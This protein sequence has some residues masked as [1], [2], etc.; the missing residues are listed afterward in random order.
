MGIPDKVSTKKGILL[1]VGCRDR[2]ERNWVGLDGTIGPDVDIVHDLERFPYPIED[3]SCITIK[4]AHVAEHINPRLF[5]RWMDELWRMLKVD[6]QLVLSAPYG[7]SI[8]YWHD[9]TH[10]CHITEVT[11][12]FLDPDFVL[13]QQYRPRPWNIEHAAWQPNGNVEAILRKRSD[14]PC[15]ELARR[16]IGLGAMQKMSELSALYSLVRQNPPRIVVE[17]GTARGGVFWGL[18][19]LAQD[20]ATIVSI[21]LPGG[22]FGGGYSE[23]DAQRFNDYKRPG[24]TVYFLRLDSHELE[25]RMKLAVAIPSAAKDNNRTIDLLFIDGDH[26]YEGVK[27]DYQMY[28]PLVR[29]GGLIVFHDICHHP[30][31]P[32]CQVEKF[33]KEVKKGKRTLE[34]IDAND[35]TWGGIGVIFK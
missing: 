15:L 30:L 2:K 10:V 17:I 8:G 27:K 22:N 26:T 33:W 7:G 14:D 9:P 12:Q 28:S 25:T 1:D 20:V 18:C 21:D 29:K 13:Y 35:Q 11:F 31:V 6:G 23:Q 5:F 4:A 19:Q 32:S 16:S 34:F 3:G 24:Q